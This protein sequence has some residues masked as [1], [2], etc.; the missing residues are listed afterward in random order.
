M[1]PSKGQIIVALAALVFLVFCVLAY[2][3]VGLSGFDRVLAE[4]WGLVTLLDVMLGAVC[5]SAVIFAQEKDKR[6]AAAWA[7]PIFLLGHVV[8]A[9]WV[10]I[11]FLP[12]VLSSISSSKA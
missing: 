12:P 9:A 10:V 3:Q 2:G 8:S 11:R 6:I 7:L 5:M 4:P 1:K